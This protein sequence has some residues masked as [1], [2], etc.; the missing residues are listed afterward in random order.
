MILG[1][2]H[3]L[4][5]GRIYFIHGKRLIYHNRDYLYH[6]SHREKHEKPWPR[7]IYPS[8][9]W[10]N[11][12]PA[13]KAGEGR[14]WRILSPLPGILVSCKPCKPCKPCSRVLFNLHSMMTRLEYISAYNV[15][16]NTYVSTINNEVEIVRIQ[17]E[18]SLSRLKRLICMPQWDVYTSAGVNNLG[19][20]GI[21]ERVQ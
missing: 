16:H 20:C 11:E 14:G 7:H 12:S 19:V 4:T 6:S 9:E 5:S 18:L 10:R 1:S 21:F 15:L 13:S 8:P 2:I 3:I 17:V